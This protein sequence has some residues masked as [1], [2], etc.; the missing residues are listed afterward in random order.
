MHAW[1]RPK[2]HL[3]HQ[4][5]TV[6]QKSP[7]T[8]KVIEKVQPVVSAH[9]HLPSLL[10]GVPLLVDNGVA[11][12][13]HS[14]PTFRIL[15]GPVFISIWAISPLWLSF[16]V[17]AFNLALTINK[18]LFFPFF[19]G[20]RGRGSIFSGLAVVGFFF[21]KAL[22]TGIIPEPTVNQIHK[23]SLSE[24][25]PGR[26]THQMSPCVAAAQTRSFS[27]SMSFWVSQNQKPE[28]VLGRNKPRSRVLD[29]HCHEYTMLPISH[30]CL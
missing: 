1:E 29:T 20:G 24:G 30:R 11:V 14:L 16:G 9:H 15:G 18:M 21:P 2:F 4:V 10:S 8:V 27:G 12:S 23:L 3:K 26:F 19:C 13:W 17:E 25:E 6:V 22:A 28:R 7:A 5:Q